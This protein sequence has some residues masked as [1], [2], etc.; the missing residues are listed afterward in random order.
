[1]SLIALTRNAGRWLLNHL[2]P[3]RC[4]GCRRHLSEK[5]P[6][7][8]SCRRAVRRVSGPRCPT[9]ALPRSGIAGR[10]T[11]GID[12]TCTD[13]RRRR[14]SQSDAHA[15]WLYDDLVAS[16]VQQ[17]KY[18]G[19]RWRLRGLA[20]PMTDWMATLAERGELAA[21]RDADDAPPLVCA[22]PMHPDEIRDRGYNTALQI[23]RR[24]TR[25]LDVAPAWGALAKTRRTP[26]QA[27]LS[28]AE[29]LDNVTDA[30]EVPRPERVADRA[31]LLIDDVVT[32]GATIA[33]TADALTDAG[34][35]A[36]SVVAM[37]R[38]P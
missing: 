16:A 36:V 1:M 28:R 27:G 9:C 13:C 24:A 4:V 20:A 22:V 3:E 21:I 15:F 8:A 19:E 10:P 5:P 37:A 18:A 29:R 2:L 17:A 23:A 33:E 14:P 38:T 12:A 6:F 7:C 26:P 32:T 25:A 11:R 31:C 34:A 35:T 30:F